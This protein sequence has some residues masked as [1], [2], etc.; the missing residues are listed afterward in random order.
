MPNSPAAK[1]E[2]PVA[3]MAVPRRELSTTT[4]SPVRSRWK[5]A[6]EMPPAMVSPPITSPKAGRVIETAGAPGT[7]VAVHSVLVV[8]ELDPNASATSAHGNGQANGHGNGNGKSGGSA[9]DEPA[10]TAVGDI[11]ENLPGMGGASRVGGGASVG[12]GGGGGLATG[13]FNDKPLATPATRK[14][15][16]DMALWH[17]KYDLLLTPVTPTAAPPVETLYNSDAFPRWT[18]GAPYTLPFNLTGAPAASMPA[19]SPPKI[20]ICM[21]GRLT[22]RRWER[23]RSADTAATRRDCGALFSAP[24]R[25]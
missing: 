14:L 19:G 16:R 3:H 22:E 18:K 11:K 7:V 21:S 9:K 6:A 17:R 24:T 1:E 20:P 8:F 23:V 2:A 5:R 15:A 12:S 25:T 10:A 13:Y 4:G